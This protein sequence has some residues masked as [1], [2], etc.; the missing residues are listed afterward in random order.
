MSQHSA[1]SSSF[2]PAAHCFVSKYTGERTWPKQV[3]AWVGKHNLMDDDEEYARDHRVNDIIVHEDWDF[4]SSSFDADVALLLLDE[5]VDLSRKHFVGV[6]CL[7]PSS[8]EAYIENGTLSGWGVSEWSLANHKTHSMTPSDLKLPAVTNDQCTEADY[9]FDELI[10]DRTFC[11]GFRNE[12]K[13]A[14]QGDSGGG[15][16]Q[17]DKFRKGF[18]LM[19]IVS[20]SIN[21]NTECNIN[22]YSVFT[23]VAKFVDWINEN[24][25]GTKDFSWK[26]VE[27]QCQENRLW[28]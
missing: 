7:P 18:S 6:I 25:E 19:G 20:G 3:V 24:V 26:K 15:F 4:D 14:C 2:V 10:S 8:S 1:R 11:A 16:W 23:D 12:G 17:Y 28:L 21:D 9:L 22:I 27:F 5:K 13:S